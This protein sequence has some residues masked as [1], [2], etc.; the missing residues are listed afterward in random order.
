[1][2][3]G[4]TPEQ[5]NALREYGFNLGV[6]FQLVDDLLD[7]TAD[8]AALGKPIGGDLR[9][10]KVTLPIIFLLQ[11]GGEDADQPDPRRR[12]ATARSRTE[13]WREI[14]APAARAPHD[15]AGLRRARSNTR[16]APRAASPRFRPSRERDALMALTD[17][18]LARDR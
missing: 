1:M 17:Y 6:A 9:E 5:E 8:E 10:G 7:Y 18:V 4:V 15:R 16:P 3:G 2:L 11:R 13:Q 12:A 14:L